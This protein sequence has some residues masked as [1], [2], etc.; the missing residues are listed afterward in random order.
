[1]LD[2][3]LAELYRIETRTLLQAVKRNSDR[4][5][6]DFMFQL[7]RDEATSLRSQF[8]ISKLAVAAGDTCPTH[9]PNTA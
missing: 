8:V 3:D 5:P 2:S 9:S 6:K 7:T 4:F 1:M